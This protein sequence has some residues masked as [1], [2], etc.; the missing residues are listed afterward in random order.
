MAVLQVSEEG[1]VLRML[2]DAD[3]RHVASTSAI[4]ETDSQI[5][6][7]NLNGGYISVLNKALLPAE[8]NVSTAGL[9]NS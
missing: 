4:M 9:I 5:F 2:M 3:G 7:G 1:K 8:I 6:I